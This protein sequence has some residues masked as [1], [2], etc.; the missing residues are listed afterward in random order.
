MH[1]ILQISLLLFRYTLS[2]IHHT[3]SVWSM[4]SEE[5]SRQTD[6]VKPNGMSTLINNMLH[7]AIG[8]KAYLLVL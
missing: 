5:Q 8:L 2:S 6:D 4:V 7:D 3:L 1:N